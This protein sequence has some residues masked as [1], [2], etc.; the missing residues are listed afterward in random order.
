MK[1]KTIENPFLTLSFKYDDAKWMEADE[2]L[3]KDYSEIIIKAGEVT[4]TYKFVKAG[5]EYTYYASSIV[6]YE[7]MSY[8]ISAQKTYQ[9]LTL[10]INGNY[11]DYQ[12]T[13]ERSRREDFSVSTKVAYAFLRS[14]RGDVDYAYRTMEGQGTNVTYQTS[15]VQLTYS[16]LKFFVSGGATFYWNSNNTY[17]TNFRGLFIQLTRNF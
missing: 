6:P 1:T 15:K 14:L 2:V 17:K 9:N 3:I 5:A 4:K 13:D 16:F 11:I 10:S 7:S 12:M 8:F